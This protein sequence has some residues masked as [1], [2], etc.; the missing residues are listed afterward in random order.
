MIMMLVHFV[1][2]LSFDVDWEHLSLAT[3]SRGC[4]IES[5]VVVAETRRGRELATNHVA[6]A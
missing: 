5:F 4:V 1:E 3:L 6:S 2:L